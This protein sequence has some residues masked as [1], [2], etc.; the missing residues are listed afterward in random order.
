MPVPA[1]ILSQKEKEK[2]PVSDGALAL[3]YISSRTAISAASPRRGP[4]FVM[5]V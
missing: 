4:I 1:A 2:R 5:R 3:I